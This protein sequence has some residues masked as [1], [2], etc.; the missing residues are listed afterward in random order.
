MEVMLTEA[1]TGAM[2]VS[3]MI[4]SDHNCARKLDIVEHVV[5]SVEK[6]LDVTIELRSV[7]WNVEHLKGSLKRF[8]ESATIYY[9]SQF[10]LC[11]KRFVIAKEIAHLLHDDEDQHVHSDVKAV[12]LVEFI[13]NPEAKVPPSLSSI[14]NSEQIAEIYALELLLP[15]SH[16]ECLSQISDREIANAYKVPLSKVELFNSPEYISLCDAAADVYAKSQ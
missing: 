8:S 10:N 6:R 11:N 16:R 9:P 1:L 7:K 14:V 3:D 15:H 12:G 13:T 2:S 4:R 5:P